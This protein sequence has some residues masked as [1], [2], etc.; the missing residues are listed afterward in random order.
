MA[1]I[2][3]IKPE[4]WTDEKVVSLSPLARLLFIGMWNFADDFGRGEYSP[5]RMKMQILPADSADIAELLGEIRREGLIEVYTVDG[6]GFFA[7]KGF[8]KHQKV[9]HRVAS[10]HPA[11]PTSADLPRNPP[12]DQGEDQ[13]REK[14]WKNSETV[15]SGAEAPARVVPIDARTALFHEGLAIIRSLVGKPEGPSRQLL[16]KWLKAAGDD[17]KLVL[18]VLQ[19]AADAQ[20]AEPVAW[21]EG[22]LKPRRA[23]DPNYRGVL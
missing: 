16:G 6:K 11:P 19:R 23:E 9:D 15:V 12:P 8:S 21:I 2:R 4:F 3:S 7:I 10:K 20:P 18:T 14:E 13:G 17:A 1:R 5:V 22:A